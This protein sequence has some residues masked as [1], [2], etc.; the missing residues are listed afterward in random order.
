MRAARTFQNISLI[1][2]GSFDPNQSKL[3]PIIIWQTG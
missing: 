2:S 1:A 3:L